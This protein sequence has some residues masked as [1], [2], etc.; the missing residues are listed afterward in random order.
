MMHQPMQPVNIGMMRMLCHQ[1]QQQVVSVLARNIN[2]E[3][4]L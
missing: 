3:P 1:V 4:F 2:Q